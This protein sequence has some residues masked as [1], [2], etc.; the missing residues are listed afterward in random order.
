[1]SAVQ[2]QSSAKI[3]VLNIC[4]FTVNCIEKTN[5][6]GYGPF[7]KMILANRAFPLIMFLVLKFL[8]MAGC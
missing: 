5:K 8:L 1:M 4:L 7:K 2:I 6:V 3:Y